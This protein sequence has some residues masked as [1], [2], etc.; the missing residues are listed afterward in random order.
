MTGFDEADLTRD[1]FLGGRLSLWQPK[2][3]YR[4]GINP[5]LLA[6]AVPAQAGQSMLDLGCGAGA[7]MLCLGMRVANMALVGIELQPGYAEL[8]RR[9]ADAA[10]LLAKV[11]QADLADMPV[12]L[13]QRSFDH[14]IANP[15]YFDPAGRSASPDSGREIAQ[16]GPTGLDRWV[17]VAARR[18]RPGGYLHM[19]N[20]AERLPDM[21]A[22]CDGQLG[23]VEILP[24]AARTGRAPG[25]VLLRARK[26]GRTT[27]KLWAPMIL[28]R[29]AQHE[30]DGDSY[31]L[32]VSGILRGGEALQWPTR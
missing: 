29:G 11:Y 22:A 15:P 4:A 31:H 30:H 8:A 9:N 5:V 10:G 2:H 32:E 12:D 19:I 17:A 28:H 27:F 24:L 6:S 23:S 26:S 14:V 25:L 1:A 7:A 18:L 13:R 20:R 3:G 16:A 21:L